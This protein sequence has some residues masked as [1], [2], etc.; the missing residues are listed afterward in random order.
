MNFRSAGADILQQIV[1]SGRERHWFTFVLEFSLA[2]ITKL[3][4]STHPFRNRVLPYLTASLLLLVSL[5][6]GIYCLATLNENR[7]QNALL[8]TAISERQADITRLKG[9]GEKVQ[10][11][12]TP[13]QK[14][15]LSASHKLVAN[16]ARIGRRGRCG[17]RRK[18][19]GQAVESE[20]AT[21]FLDEVYIPKQI[22]SEG[23]RHD[24]P[25]VGGRRDVEPQSAQNA[26][27]FGIRHRRAQ[28]PREP[29]PPKLKASRR[30]WT[31]IAVDHRTANTA[32]ANLLHQRDCP[33]DCEDLTTD[34]GAALESRRCFG[35]EAEALARASN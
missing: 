2:V 13:E 23:W 25:S 24:V 31:G 30:A 17:H 7:K 15:L 14:A 11:L 26:P 34:I 22:H 10:Q 9:E 19:R 4:L 28:Q 21:D 6:V 35:L 5:A 12:L 3:N 33:L 16:T 1:A 8:A 32:G 20:M 18:R 27:D 29:I